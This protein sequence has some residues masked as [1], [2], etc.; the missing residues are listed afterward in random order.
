[1]SELHLPSGRADHLPTQARSMRTRRPGEP[2]DDQVAV[3]GYTTAMIPVV[4]LEG[5]PRERGLAYGE[6][7]RDLIVESA[8]RWTADAGPDQDRV[9]DVLV[10]TSGFQAAVEQL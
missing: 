9:L 2:G 5:R 10:R 1:M 4:V 7:A 8:S 6:T 3:S